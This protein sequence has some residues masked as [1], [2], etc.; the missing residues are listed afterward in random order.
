MNS[1]K[2]KGTF[3]EMLGDQV[4][5]VPRG[6]DKENPALD[7]LRYKQFWFERSFSDKEA[8]D[9]NFLQEINRTFVN[10]RP[11]FDY[12]SEVLTTDLNGESIVQGY[13]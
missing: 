4:K 7:L 2:L 11:F 9:K 3:G 10:I 13:R 6:F 5:T 12:M 8:F 1:R